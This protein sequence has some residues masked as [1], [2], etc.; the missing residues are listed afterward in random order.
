MVLAVRYRLGRGYDDVV[1][2]MHAHAQDILHVADDLAVVVLVAHDLVFD[3]LPVTDV[4]LYQDL[5]GY[6]KGKAPLHDLRELLLIARDPASAP[7]EGVRDSDDDGVANL[8]GDL[9]R[10][11]ERVSRLAPRTVDPD[12]QHRLLEQLTVLRDLYPVDGCAED[13]DSIFLQNALPLEADPAVEGCL[14]S[15]SQQYRVGSLLGDYLRD[16]I[17]ADWKEVD[18]VCYPP[19]SLNRRDVRVDEDRFHAFFLQS[20]EALAAGVVELAAAS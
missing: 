11:L 10:L 19:V 3:L 15:E 20:L 17:R 18:L 8:D 2:R 14:T 12:L 5:M 1:S 7:S 13:L 4:L 9:A 16:E 6:A